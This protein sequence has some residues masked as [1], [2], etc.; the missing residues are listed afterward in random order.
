M[1]KHYSDLVVCQAETRTMD[2]LDLARELQDKFWIHRTGHLM[3]EGESLATLVPFAQF[4]ESQL[5]K[6]AWH[7][8]HSKK[9]KLKSQS[10]KKSTIKK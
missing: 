2:L 4:L 9:K 6:V 5:E 3:T 1:Y 8:A 7:H 10:K